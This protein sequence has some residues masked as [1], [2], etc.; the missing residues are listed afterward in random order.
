[1]KRPLGLTPI[2]IICLLI[3]GAWLAIVGAVLPPYVRLVLQRATA[4]HMYVDRLTISPFLQVTLTGVRYTSNT[5]EA[6]VSVQRVVLTPGWISP[7]SKHLTIAS[8]RVERPVVRA[9][10]TGANTVIWPQLTWPT[11]LSE[12][13]R[14]RVHI[15]SLQII[16][17]VAEWIDEAPSPAFHG[18]LDHISF[19]AGG[20]RWPWQQSQLN[21]A[22]RGLITGHQGQA[23]TAYCS[24]WADLGPRDFQITCQLEPLPLA[25]FDP[26]FHGP[27]ELRVYTT[28]LKSTSQW[29]G[30]LNELTGRVQLE[31]AHLSE[32]DLSVRGRT[33]AD[34]KRLIASDDPRIRGEITV[35]GPA[36]NPSQWSAE[37]LPGDPVVQQLIKRLLSRGVEM[38]KV[39]FLGGK[40]PVNI[41]PGSEAKMTDIEAASREVQEALELLTAPDIEPPPVEPV[42]PTE[43]TVPP[44][45]QG[46][47]AAEP[48]APP[49]AEEPAPPAAETPTPSAEPT[50]PAEPEVAPA[51]PAPPAEVQPP[52]SSSP[53]PATR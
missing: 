43:E 24:G 51:L 5:P 32:G 40:L 28:T 42:L 11:P 17:G 36:D 49:A 21:F 4:G 12:S 15:E 30:S 25:A 41:A 45:E 7:G 33:I 44:T 10:R 8:L 46:A 37:F 6:G 1:M 27:T 50:P 22:I 39:P 19:E 47:S 34:I 29:S 18:A 48:P 13:S 14:W 16:D 26:Y 52:A 3:I 2:L 23:A 53:P 38:V 31:L 20:F 9:M 35:S